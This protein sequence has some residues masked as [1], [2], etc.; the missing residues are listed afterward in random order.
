M[1]NVSYECKAKLSSS[2]IE[3]SSIYTYDLHFQTS[4]PIPIEELID[5]IKDLEGIND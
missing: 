4:F 5:K 2:R 3:G 1:Y